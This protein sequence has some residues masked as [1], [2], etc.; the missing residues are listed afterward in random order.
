MNIREQIR[1]ID[2]I[3]SFD[4][5][6]KELSRKE[7][8]TICPP[9]LF[10]FLD[11]VIPSLLSKKIA[12]DFVEAGVWKGGT[13][14]YMKYLC[15]KYGIKNK[16]WLFDTFN[17]FEVVPSEI[18]AKDKKMFELFST[19]NISAPGV[20]EVK[21]NFRSL[22]LL[23]DSVRFVKGNILKTLPETII[24]DIS[25]LHID[26]DFAELTEKCLEHLYPE[27]VP[28]GIVIV[29]DYGVEEFNCREAVDEYRKQNAI[30]NPL[31]FINEHMVYWYK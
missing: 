23:D 1:S 21:N 26:L 17:G 11:T 3:T 19:Y 12:G 30:T 7:C 16:L 15:K 8:L 6:E 10:D 28:G 31:S 9:E 18:H 14:M 13:G 5:L 27:L 22:E 4:E 24:P 25:L 20:E 29:D 2:R